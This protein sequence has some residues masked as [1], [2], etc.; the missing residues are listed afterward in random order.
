MLSLTNS[1][2]EASV[3]S[4]IFSGF[5]TMTLRLMPDHWKPDPT[6]WRTRKGAEPSQPRDFPL[7]FPR[8]SRRV[9]KIS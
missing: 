8:V 5:L 1:I 6:L 4:K 9:I 2:L 7:E 3:M